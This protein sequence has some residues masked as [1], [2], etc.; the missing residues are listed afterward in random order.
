M[1]SFKKHVTNMDEE[2]IKPFNKMPR[3]NGATAL[4]MHS[5]YTDV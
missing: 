2:T 1:A 3:L 4:V 5:V